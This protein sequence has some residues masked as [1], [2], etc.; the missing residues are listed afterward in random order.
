M[1]KLTTIVSIVLAFNANSQIQQDKVLHFNA[2][3]VIT[4][5]VNL[6]VYN[7]TKSI[8]SAFVFGAGA[9]LIAGAGKEGFDYMTGG[10]V[11][12][13]DFVATGLGVIA[14]SFV[15]IGIQEIKESRA[16]KINYE[17]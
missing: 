8:G 11:S 5:G 9:G 4:S 15:M 2:G 12:L 16:R 10:D 7:D 13:G 17:L 14:S 6:Y 3:A 1:K